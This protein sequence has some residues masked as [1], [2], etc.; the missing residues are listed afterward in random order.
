MRN[1]RLVFHELSYI[2]PG[3]LNEA[4]PVE[5]IN[6]KTVE[7]VQ[8]LLQENINGQSLMN[9]IHVIWF[10]VRIP[11]GNAPVLTGPDHELLASHHVPRILIFP[12]YDLT[13]AQFDEELSLPDNISDETAERLTVQRAEAHFQDVC[14]SQVANLD[15]I[16]AHT[17]TGGLKGAVLDAESDRTIRGLL[18]TTC[19]LGNE[20]I[21]RKLWEVERTRLDSPRKTITEALK[22]VM[23]VYYPG[24]FSNIPWHTQGNMLDQ[25]HRTLTRIWKMD[26]PRMR[27]DAPPF[28]SQVHE[29]STAYNVHHP[30]IRQIFIG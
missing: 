23:N 1:P 13:V 10:C 3:G 7:I 9:Q 17:R 11:S 2:L 30:G 29:L 27:R 16:S 5:V 28:V 14:R 21:E 22:I 20:Y 15:M 24:A 26:D 6:L 18:E 19:L 25:L 12:R 4:R 8:R